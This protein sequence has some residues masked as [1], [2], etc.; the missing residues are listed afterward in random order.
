MTLY[1]R[2]ETVSSTVKS[3]IETSASKKLH[4]LF[5]RNADLLLRIW[6][7]NDLSWFLKT[8]QESALSHKQVRNRRQ[9]N[10]GN[11]KQNMEDKNTQRE[12]TKIRTV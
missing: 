2:F 8:R 6:Y 3:Y 12:R 4:G 5:F 9:A 11:L 10:P 7:Q 1:A